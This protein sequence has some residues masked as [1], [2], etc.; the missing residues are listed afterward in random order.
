MKKIEEIKKKAMPVL[1]KFSV[2][3]AGIFGSYARGEQ[4]EKSDVDFLIEIEG[5]ADLVELIRL[6][7]NLQ[8]AISKKV[9]LV[10]Y[11]AIKKELKKDILNDEIRLI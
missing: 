7:S 8:K 2:T 11:G 3:R 4:N 5:G 10:E 1:K 6:K 9:D